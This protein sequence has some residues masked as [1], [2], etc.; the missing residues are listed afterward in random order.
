MALPSGRAY[1]RNIFFWLWFGLVMVWLREIFFGKVAEMV[2]GCHATVPHD[3]P[4]TFRSRGGGYEQNEKA[5]HR[6]RERAEGGNLHPGI[7][8]MAGRQRQP[9]ATTGRA[10]EVRR[11]GAGHKELR[12]LRG[13]RVQRQ[14]HRPASLPADDGEGPLRGVFPHTGVED[15]PHKPEPAGLCLH[16]PGAQGLRRDLRVQERAI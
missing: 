8:Q 10:A 13:R 16:V 14:E 4:W 2:Y 5:H 3:V 15:R 6:H 7:H 9:S 11:A 1:I 12:G